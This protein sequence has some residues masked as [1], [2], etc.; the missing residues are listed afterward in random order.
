MVF[1]VKIE[2]PWFNFGSPATTAHDFCLLEMASSSFQNHV[3]KIRRFQM[4]DME[5]ITESELLSRL[6]EDDSG[7]HDRF[8]IV[9]SEMKDR[10]RRI[11]KF[12]M[13]YRL[14]G[15]VSDS[16]VLQDSYLRAADRLNRFLDN[17]EFPFFV[18]LRLQVQQQ[19]ADVHRKHLIAEKRDARKEIT[20]NA[21]SNR[22]A[23]GQTSMALAAHLVAQLTSASRLIERSEEIAALEESL[24]EMNPIDREVIALRHFEELSSSETADVLGIEPAAASKRYVRALKRLKEIMA[25]HGFSRGD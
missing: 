7:R 6:R 15:R 8:A 16:D 20:L 5:E 17:P 10:L 4:I 13:D 23:S 9:F 1:R 19:V 3:S 21:V 2:N 18:W 14:V 11:V 12:R 22:G 25:K 24:N